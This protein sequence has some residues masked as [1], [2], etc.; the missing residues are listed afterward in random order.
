MLDERLETEPDTINVKMEEARA[1]NEA[2]KGGPILDPWLKRVSPDNEQ[3]QKYLTILSGM[4]AMSQVTI[5]SIDSRLPVYHGTDDKTLQ[6]GLGHLYGSSLPIG[7]EGNHS[8]ITGH[9][10]ITN[11]TLWDSLIDVEIGDAIYVNTFG[12]KM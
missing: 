12:E 10:G 9:T 7:G 6:K 8:V 2:N 4:P 11:A 3:Y 1:Y 5:P